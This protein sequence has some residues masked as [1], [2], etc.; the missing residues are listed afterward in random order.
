MKKTYHARGTQGGESSGRRVERVYGAPF[1]WIPASDPKSGAE[2]L[3][4]ATNT[5]ASL[6][7]TMRMASSTE[8]G[9]LQTEEAAL[10]L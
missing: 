7:I 10:K 6:A 2:Y 5:H 9:R 4:Q 8:D 1:R 3:V